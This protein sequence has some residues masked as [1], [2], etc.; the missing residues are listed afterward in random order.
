MN[1]TV[2]EMSTGQIRWVIENAPSL[3]SART[4]IPPDWG[5][6]AT[7]ELIDPNAHFVDVGWPDLPVVLPKRTFAETLSV[8]G[9]VATLSSLPIPCTVTVDRDRYAVADG[10]I[11]IEF[12][13]PG[14]YRLR[15]EAMH[16][17]TK[18]LEVEL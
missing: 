2:F 4:G 9:Q 16:Y 12:A 3:D 17:L 7:P 13:L 10:E 8:D 1:L 6:L 18:T 5:V 15:L 11:E 14:K